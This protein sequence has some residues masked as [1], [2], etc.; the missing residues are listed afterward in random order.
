MDSIYSLA[1]IFDSFEDNEFFGICAHEEH[2][3]LITEI[4]NEINDGFDM[5]GGFLVFYN[6]KASE[7]ECCKN[8]S[9]AKKL[10]AAGISEK[11]HAVN[12]GKDLSKKI[13]GQEM[14]IIP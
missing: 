8:I 6:C 13:F 1:C 4:M 5:Q 14:K 2:Q 10:A 12:I 3:N 9:A 7:E 11:G